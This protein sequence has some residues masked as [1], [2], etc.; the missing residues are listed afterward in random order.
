MANVL[1][2]ELRR[3]PPQWLGHHPQGAD[4][5]K[6]GANLQAQGRRPIHPQPG[7]KRRQLT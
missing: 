5:L 7:K 3:Q 4:R 2:K 1:V 6:P